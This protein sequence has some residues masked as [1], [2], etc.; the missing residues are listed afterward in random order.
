MG[1]GQCLISRFRKRRLRGSLSALM[2]ER[3]GQSSMGRR[4]D[5]VRSPEKLSSFGY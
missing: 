3:E 2:L 5:G 1:V 4:Q